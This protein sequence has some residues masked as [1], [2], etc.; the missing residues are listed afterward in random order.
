MAIWISALTDAEVASLGAGRDPRTL[1][2]V[3]DHF[4]TMVGGVQD[5]TGGL[6]WTDNGT[7]NAGQIPL[8][9]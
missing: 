8:G 3:P 7:A 4:L 9:W 1:A 6:T 5:T 2:T